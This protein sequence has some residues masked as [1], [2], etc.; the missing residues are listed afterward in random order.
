MPLGLALSVFV[1][2]LLSAFCSSA[3]ATFPGR[4]GLL[5]F[6]AYVPNE[7]STDF[8]VD[9]SLVGLSHVPRGPRRFLAYG[10]DPAFSPDGRWIAY[11]TDSRPEQGIWLTRP[12]CHWPGTR[13]RPAPCSRLR[14]LTRGLDR[15]PAWTQDG[16]RIAF[17]RGGSIHTVRAERGGKR[18][19]VRGESPDWSSRGALAFTRNG[20]LLVRRPGGP[21][22]NL[23]VKGA[24]PSW[25]PSGER[26]AFI[27]DPE[28]GAPGETLRTINA[29]G[30]GLRTLWRVTRREW[31]DDPQ[32]EYARPVSPKWSPD[33]R[34]IAFIESTGPYTTGAVYTVSPRGG[35]A[36]T[37]MPRAPKCPPCIDRPSFGNLAW[38][39]LRR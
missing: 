5:G 31:V 21:I 6:G 24:S 27:G 30:S 25:A 32:G 38:Q 19:L 33:G 15:F 12:D 7:E 39:P 20:Q 13:A 11:S 37:L 35:P 9:A 10:D 22:L 34:S 1:M 2:V 4:N 8:L 29:D 3:W 17:V 36:R 28:A 23:G 26:L 18:F 16:K 14:R